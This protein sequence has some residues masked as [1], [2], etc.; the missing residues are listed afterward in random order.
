MTRKS[1]KL[2]IMREKSPN[3]YFFIPSKKIVSNFDIDITSYW[4]WVNRFIRYTPLDLPDG[5]GKCGSIGPYNWTIQTYIYLKLFKYKYHITD[6]L[7]VDGIII[8][9]S[10]F[11]PRYIKPKSNRFIVEIKPDRSLKS[12]FANFVIIQNIYDPIYQGLRRFFISS[13]YI[14]YWPQPSIIKRHLSRGSKIKNVCYIGKMEQFISNVN[15]LK[16]EVKKLGMNFKIVP[17]KEWNDYSE[18]DVIVAVRRKADNDKN[19]V[20]SNLSTSKKPAS[21][22][23][24]SW[25]AGVPAIL[26]RD[27]AFLRLKKTENDFLEADNLNEIIIQLKK[28]R[29][30]PKLFN[31]MIKNGIERSEVFYPQAIAKQWHSLI[32]KKIIPNYFIWKN[33]FYRRF[34]TIFFR[35]IFYP[36]IFKLI[37][38]DFIRHS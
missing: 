15:D 30:D 22:L 24:N 29:S 5:S 6:S 10:D 1:V 19:S 13:A 26:S 16:K 12:I 37:C 35:S 11:L 34:F 21:K 7:N 2:H 36:K 33:S 4:N 25:I 18:I 28:L 27:D 3:I 32:Q 17:K 14:D 8:S 20:A 38:R 31:N 9:H 23:I